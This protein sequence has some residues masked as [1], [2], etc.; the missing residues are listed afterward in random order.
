MIDLYRIRDRISQWFRYP[1][2]SRLEKHALGLYTDSFDLDFTARR[3][4]AETSAQYVIDHMRQ[5]QNF[6]TDYDLHD[7]A[8]KQ[9]D[10]DLLSPWGCGLILEFGVATGRTINH[11]AR[12]LPFNVIHGFDGFVGLPEH[13]TWRMRKGHFSQPLPRVRKNVD[14]H[15]GWFDATLEPFLRENTAPVAFL[16]IDSDLYSSA[17]FVLDRLARRLRVGTIIVFDEYLN[18]P[19]WQ[20][21]EYRAWQEVTKAWGIQYEYIGFV[22]RHQQVAVRITKAA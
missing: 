19:G 12:R 4:A 1:Q 11:F 16:H 22:S 10:L 15:V 21:D 17:A 7:W 18:Y 13:W 2:P 9:V 20:Q 8:V 5:A 3:L 14:L 6:P